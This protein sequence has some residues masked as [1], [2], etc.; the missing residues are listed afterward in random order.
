MEEEAGDSAALLRMS[1]YRV[2]TDM[3][4]TSREAICL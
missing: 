3:R 1:R 4:V 2:N